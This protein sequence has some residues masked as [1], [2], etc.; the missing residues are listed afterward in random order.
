MM[1]VA[2][3]R[4]QPDRSRAARCSYA[5]AGRVRNGFSLVELAIAIAIIGLLLSG[6][7]APL[8]VRVEERQ[9]A[10][11]RKELES[12][13]EAMLGFAAA[14]GY[15][16]CP[17]TGADGLENV[18]GSQC[19]TISA[20]M[21]CGR[22]PHVILGLAPSD[23]WGN[24]YTYCVNE[25]F[26]RR[27]L[28]LTF[29]LGTAGNNVSICTIQS[30]ATTISTTAIAAVVSHGRNG[31]G[32]TNLGTGTQNPAA[33]HQDEQEN[34]DTDG[35]IVARTRTAAG[36]AAGEFDDIVMWLP[37][38]VLLNRMITAGKLP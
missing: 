30:C 28:G 34:Y 23:V 36:A 35:I 12:I 10:E 8:H 16:P 25:L 37:R 33:P 20:G 27:G 9:I 38:S 21:A 22:L 17:D 13:R 32:A 19:T 18:T 1:T 26:A 11:T 6:F 3:Y 2:R 7:L 24:R 14:Q 5:C 4:P 29:T 31:Y 15:L